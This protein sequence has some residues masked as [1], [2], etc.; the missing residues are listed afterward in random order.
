MTLGCPTPTAV[1][2]SK[3]GELRSEAFAT[4]VHLARSNVI[5]AGLAAPNGQLLVLAVSDAVNPDLSCWG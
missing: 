5:V 3:W 4:D 1:V 2:D